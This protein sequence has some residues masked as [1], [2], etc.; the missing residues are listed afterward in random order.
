MFHTLVNI[1]IKNN[2][3][4]SDSQVFMALF[5]AL[6]SGLLSLRLGAALYR[7]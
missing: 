5:V 4:L 6:L 1:F 3:P 2:M 7:A